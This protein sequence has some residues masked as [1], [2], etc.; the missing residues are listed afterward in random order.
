MKWT[1]LKLTGPSGQQGG[2]EERNAQ[3]RLQRRIDG[4]HTAVAVNLSDE[5]AVIDLDRPRELEP[6]GGIFVDV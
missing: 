3:A 1:A 5:P 2:G 4:E 6:W